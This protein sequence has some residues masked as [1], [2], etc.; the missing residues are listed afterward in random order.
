MSLQ[1]RGTE[2][3]ELLRPA[4][5][6][7]SLGDRVWVTTLLFV[8]FVIAVLVTMITGYRSQAELRLQERTR[9]ISVAYETVTSTLAATP[10]LFRAQ[11]ARD[12]YVT[13]IMAEA[14]R[15]AGATQDQ[16]RARLYTHLRDDYAIL[17]EADF[18]QL[19]FQLTNNHSFLRFHRPERY[20]DD[21]TEARP[22]V[23]VTNHT[24]TP[25]YG[26]EEGRIYNGFRFVYPLF[27]AGAHVGSVEASL[28]YQA[29]ISR[30]RS[31]RPMVYDFVLS[32]HAIES[33]VFEEEQDNYEPFVL[34]DRD[35]KSVV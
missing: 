16:L 25:T 11:L 6:L 5:R 24:Q 10:E 20:G 17:R 26:F 2:S 4:Y 23:R 30:M 7:Q 1:E 34:S 3:L 8:G 28:S 12:P 15:D 21:L 9:E 14:N 31:S 32:R 13:G 22:T 33:I 27:H 29:V 19:H 18:R 35:W